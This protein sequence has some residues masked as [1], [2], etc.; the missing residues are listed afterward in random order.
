[1]KKFIFTPMWRFEK[2]EKILSEYEQNGK[3]LVGIKFPYIFEFKEATPKKADYLFTVF[4]RIRKSEMICI[5]LENDLKAKHK[6]LPVG[7]MMPMLGLSVFRSIK[8][9]DF[10]EFKKNRKSLLAGIYLGYAS[11][12]LFCTVLFSLLF[13]ASM[14]QNNEADG[15]AFW[16][17]L[18]SFFVLLSAYFIFGYIKERY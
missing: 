12:S 17:I 14:R 7:E 1:M 18:I 16:I 11:L 9:N 15:I 5:S 10:T 8:N 13:Y 6:C 2:T 4:S 3:R